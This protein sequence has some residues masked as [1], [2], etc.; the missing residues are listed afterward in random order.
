MKTFRASRK[1][2]NFIPEPY[3]TL[4]YSSNCEP[5]SP[6]MRLAICLYRIG[7]GY[8]LYTIA[9]MSG[10]G[11]SNVSSI[12]CQDLVD[13][14][15]NET[16]SSHV[17]QTEEGFKQKLSTKNNFGNVLAA[18]QHY[19]GCHIPK[20]NPPKWLQAC[21]EYHNFKNFYSI[22]LTAVVDSNYFRSMKWSR[23]IQTSKFTCAKPDY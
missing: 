5:I 23:L 13:H 21:K 9:E 20:K 14:L 4:P 18:E 8:Y 22:E 15:W 17:P 16:V 10:L 3:W 2:F 6:A 7:R 19:S 1:T 12:C 11:I